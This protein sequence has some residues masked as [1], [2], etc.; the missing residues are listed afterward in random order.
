MILHWKLFSSLFQRLGE[1]NLFKF[2]HFV[3]DEIEDESKGSY[4]WPSRFQEQTTSPLLSINVDLSVAVFFGCNYQRPWI[5]ICLIISIL[6]Y[7]T[8]LFQA[9]VAWIVGITIVILLSLE[10]CE[11]CP[12]RLS[13]N[14][15]SS[16]LLHYI[17]SP[18]NLF[19]CPDQ[20][21]VW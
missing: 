7:N 17:I 1:E 2:R 14:M 3:L 4:A 13:S 18:R 21:R 20:A 10:L 9:R 19:W 8:H 12:L 11:R 5:I 16:N 15:L 6:F